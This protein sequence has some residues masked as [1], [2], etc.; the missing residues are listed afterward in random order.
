MK[1]PF[2]FASLIPDEFRPLLT[3]VSPV[4]FSVVE[5]KQVLKDGP[6]L[7]RR[8]AEGVGVQDLKDSLPTYW[9]PVSAE[10]HLGNAVLDL[11]FGQIRNPNGLFLDL[12]RKHFIFDQRGFV[13]FV[14][15]GFWVKWS[16]RFRVGLWNIYSGY[17][18]DKPEE[19]ENGLFQI[20]LISDTMSSEDRDE[21]RRMLIGH[22]GGEYRH[23]KFYISDFTS[24]FERFFSFLVRKNI[25]LSADFLYL[26]IY[27]A[28][29]YHCLQEEGGSYDVKMRFLKTA[30][31]GGSAP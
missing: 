18:G 19:V 24:S 28:S 8:W 23:Q 16:E 29:L 31:I 2:L 3:A 26:G 14:P 10:T 5:W 7:V 22:I 20:G 27:L 15:N 17:Y 13:S 12:R 9:D 11:Y 25:R 6:V 30:S 1:T 21:V 4:A